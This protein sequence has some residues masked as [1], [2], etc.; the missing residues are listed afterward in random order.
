MCMIKL[1]ITI[2]GRSIHF[3]F[4]SQSFKI[5]IKLLG[6]SFLQVKHQDNFDLFIFSDVE[7]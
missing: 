5:L 3:V 2:N 7:E 4:S 1:L 6:I